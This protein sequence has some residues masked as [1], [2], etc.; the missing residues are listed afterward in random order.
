MTALT[1]LVEGEFAERGGYSPKLA[2]PTSPSTITAILI[3]P[4]AQL[5]II[6]ELVIK[7]G[8]FGGDCTRQTRAGSLLCAALV[9][10]AT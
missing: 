2:L 8:Q 7:V 1:A 5:I 3:D 10:T 6:G 9:S 4:C